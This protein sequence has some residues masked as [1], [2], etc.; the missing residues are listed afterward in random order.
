MTAP[1]AA[2]LFDAEP[3]V[4]AETFP[5]PR[6]DDLAAVLYTSGTTGRPKGAMLTQDNLASNALALRSAWGFCADD[7]LVHALPIFHTHGLFVATNTVLCC[8]ASMRFLRR[9]EPGA[10]LD[11][12]H[13][14]TVLMGVPTFYTRLLGDERLTESACKNIRLFISGS[15]PLLA[16]THAAF[17]S[18]TGQAIL[19]RYGMTELSMITSNPLEGERR[20]GSVGRPLDRVVVRI[21]DPDEHGIGDVEV[22]GPNVFPGYW[23]RPDLQASEFT[24]DG[25]F[26]TGDLGH[27]DDD[28]Y[29]WL[30]GRSKDLVISGGLNV[31]PGELE[32][33]ARHAAW[34]A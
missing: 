22:Q 25:F 1:V 30:A 4:G 34:G 18:C 2:S 6:P 17:A 26:R 28:G 9:F 24:A 32:R 7:V 14:A 21:A 23:R 27:L 16:S 20:A 5:T 19:E 33:R 29:L 12:L 11:A 13:D 3:R 15:A 8:G 31:Y 10:V